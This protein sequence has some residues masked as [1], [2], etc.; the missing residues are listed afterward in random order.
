VTETP[1]SSNGHENEKV[2]AEG[3]DL[4]EENK[5]DDKPAD[6]ISQNEE[7]AIDA[8]SVEGN[9]SPGETREDADPGPSNEDVEIEAVPEETDEKNDQGTADD[10]GT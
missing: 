8:S 4:N 5:E 7:N 10:N 9:G 2:A 6:E 3:E 1:E